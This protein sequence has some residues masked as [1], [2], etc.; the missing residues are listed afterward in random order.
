M[1]KAAVRPAMRY[2]VETRALKKHKHYKKKLLDN[3]NNDLSER[4]LSGEEAKDCANWTRL[5]RRIDST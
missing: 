5:I 2:G 4:G 3:S 1:Y